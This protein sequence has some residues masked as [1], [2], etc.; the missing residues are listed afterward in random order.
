MYFSIVPCSHAEAKTSLPVKRT[1]LS[2][3]FNKQ[4]VSSKAEMPPWRISIAE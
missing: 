4:E 2:S 1:F 3:S